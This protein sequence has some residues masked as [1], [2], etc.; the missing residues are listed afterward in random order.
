MRISYV[1]S[2]DRHIRGKVLQFEKILV[3]LRIA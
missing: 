3:T 2:V 1:T